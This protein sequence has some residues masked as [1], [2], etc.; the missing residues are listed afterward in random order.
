MCMNVCMYIDRN[1]NLKSGWFILVNQTLVSEQGS[2][3][4]KK[5]DYN[6]SFA[7]ENNSFPLK[8]HRL[9]VRDAVMAYLV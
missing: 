7:I 9:K 5:C 4:T 2:R 3:P 8:P 6:G 1:K